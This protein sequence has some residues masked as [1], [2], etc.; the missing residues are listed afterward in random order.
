MRVK[1][2]PSHKSSWQRTQDRITQVKEVL[3][4]P[5]HYSWLPVGFWLYYVKSDSQNWIHNMIL[6]QG[7]SSFSAVCQVAVFNLHLQT[8]LDWAKGQC[9]WQLR[10]DWL[11]YKYK[12]LAGGVDSSWPRYDTWCG[13]AMIKHD[14]SPLELTAT[15]GL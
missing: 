7:G 4:S 10:H 2:D 1:Y 9:I 15:Q 12:A 14:L 13:T 6:L 8:R 5:H 3:D 11:V